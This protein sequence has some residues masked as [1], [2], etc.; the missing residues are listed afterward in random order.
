M[1]QYLTKIILIVLLLTNSMISQE[2]VILK[3]KVITTDPYEYNKELVQKIN[4]LRK[5]GQRELIQ[6]EMKKIFNFSIP[7]KA[8]NLEDSTFK[9]NFNT[10]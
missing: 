9:R 1:K 10:I 7:K 2:K 8:K 4:S 6:E 5:S 3:N